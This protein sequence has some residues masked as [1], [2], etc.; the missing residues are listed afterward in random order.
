MF[1]DLIY[2]QINLQKSWFKVRLY[3]QNTKVLLIDIYNKN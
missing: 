3:H 1:Y 2:L